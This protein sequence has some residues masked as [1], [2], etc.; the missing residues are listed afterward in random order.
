L[1]V[2]KLSGVIARASHYERLAEQYR[3]STGRSPLSSLKPSRGERR[4]R[5]TCCVAALADNARTIILVS[6]RQLGSRLIST[7]PETVKTKQV[8]PRWWLMYAGNDI[9]P[10]FSIADAIQAELLDLSGGQAAVDAGTTVIPEI[11]KVEKGVKKCVE[12]ERQ[13]QIE[14]VYLRPRGWS[15]ETFQQQAPSLP[16]SLVTQTIEQ[17]YGHDMPIELL[18]AGFDR[19]GY[20]YLFTIYGNSMYPRRHDNPGY[21]A[22]GSG[23]EAAM[24]WMG[25]RDIGYASESREVLY[26]AIEGKYF[27]ELSLGVGEY[28]DVFILRADKPTIKLS[29]DRVD[30]AIIKPIVEKLGPRDIGD[31]VR[32]KLNELPELHD[33][34]PLKLDK[35]KPKTKPV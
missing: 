25:Y 10:I 26:S 19:L 3:A 4:K 7:D 13:T 16:K 15:L 11:V 33:F 8:H 22:I 27:A 28:T 34:P 12:R 17:L 32:R 6:D 5:M 23:G 9:A 31:A 1:R 21:A 20:G 18:L 30:E 2:S 24:Y 29:D 35:D 14:A